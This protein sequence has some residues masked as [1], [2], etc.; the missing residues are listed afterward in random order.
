MAKMKDDDL[1]Q[2]LKNLEQDASHYTFGALR[3]QREAAARDYQQRPYGNEEEGWSQIVTSDVQD[4]IEWI[5][6]ELLSKFVSIDDAVVFEPTRAADVMGAQQATDA[7]NYVFYKQNNGFHVLYT[8]FKDALMFKNGVVHWRTETKQ[9]VDK[10]P[11]RGVD[12]LRVEYEVSQGWEVPKDVE[13][14]PLQV[15]PDPVT[16]LPM[17]GPQLY[18]LT[19]T[20]QVERKT[21]RVEAF[22]PETLNV[23][24]DWTSPLLDDCPYV[25]RTLYVSLSDLRQM[26]FKAD[27]EDLAGSGRPS[28]AG[29]DPLTRNRS[30]D[31]GMYTD[32]P[33]EVDSDDESLTMGYLR[34][35][36]V[37]ADRDGDGIAERLE[38]YRLEDKILSVEE[39]SQVPVAT[40]SPILVQH[41]HIGMSV[42]ETVADLQQLRTELMRQVVN[43]AYLSNNPRKVVQVDTNGAPLVDVEDLLD[44]RPGGIIRAKR[45][46]AL[47][48]DVTPFVGN[49]MFG[50]ME[51]IDQMREQRT[52]VSKQQQGL[53]PNA[54]R[55]DRTAQEV[56]MTANAAKQR[57]NLIARI[58]AE[59]MVKPMFKGI[60]R[61]LME[62]DM[63]PLAFQ[64]RGEFVEVDPNEW[65]DGYDMTI[66]VGLGTGDK[67]KQLQVLNAMSQKQLQLAASPLQGLV[68]PMQIYRVQ[69][70]MLDIAGFKNADDF[71]TKPPDG[72]MPAPPPQ[73][74]PYQ[75]AVKQ[76]ELQAEAQ[77]LQYQARLDGQKFQAE[78]ELKQREVQ[79]QFEKE[80]Q[81]DQR[82]FER[83][84]WEAQS[85][86]RLK[87]ADIEA[88]LQ[89]AAERNRTSVIVARIA[90]P[91]TK[92]SDLDIDPET[93][94]TYEKIDPMLGLLAG[95]QA[96]AAQQFAPKEVVRDAVTGK[97]SGVRQGNAVQSVVRDESGR[98][99]GLQ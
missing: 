23:K 29:N 57:V 81:N 37:L 80:A 69:Q 44:G 1:L 39:C 49:Q 40:G 65:R 19:M 97:I 64:L 94:Q 4:T 86:E 36:W 48:M 77:R 25:S 12:R 28:G 66:N 24:R 50:M 75:I 3:T 58:F 84:Q 26:G 38:V 5:L 59:T 15:I 89:E 74:P 79:L 72:P 32:R 91:E 35:E 22:D 61:L 63:Q 85:A 20:R 62:G 52:G 9:T 6:P 21:V 43:N 13:E 51:Y 96:I 83:W 11:L 17:P 33:A 67:E 8:M 90:H 98:V 31:D 42:A 95:V 53:D 46:D 7:C 41:Q 71:F 30:S 70:K 82:D 93:G 54:L 56:V 2:T 68:T 88:K 87:L 16:G 45:P 78:A 60:L 92:L 34:I 47:N 55:N 14:L 99:V 18:N 76:M 27:A 73:A 10:L